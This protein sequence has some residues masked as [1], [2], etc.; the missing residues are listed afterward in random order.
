MDLPDLGD[1][2]LVLVRS[3]SLL[4]KEDG[5]NQRAFFESLLDPLLDPPE[6]DSRF[7]EPP[8]PPDSDVGFRLFLLR[9]NRKNLLLRLLGLR[10]FLARILALDVVVLDL[11]LFLDV[12]G[13]DL[14]FLN[15]KTLLHLDCFPFSPFLSPFFCSFFLCSAEPCDFLERFWNCLK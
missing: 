10:R 9:R 4:I 2:A 1:D 5:R 3:F 7:L 15:L 14:F 8:S 6:A 11:L 13:D 12:A